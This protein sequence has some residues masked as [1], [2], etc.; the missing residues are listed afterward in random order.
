MFIF[1]TLAVTLIQLFSL[2]IFVLPNFAP[3]WTVPVVFT[4][5]LGM[6][7]G[8][9]YGA[10]K[11]PTIGVVIMGFSLG[12]L[13]GFIIYWAFISTSV[14]TQIAKTITA[15]ATGLFMAFLCFFLADH[16]VIITSGIFGAYLF[17]RG[18]SMYTGGYVNEFTVI[19]ATNNGD[20]G[21]IKW[22]MILYW[23]LMVLMAIS[24]IMG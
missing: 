12:S 20:L 16:M 14:D 15:G 6:G 19:L 5:C 22:T 11:W 1:A 24:G 18:I 21:E 17:I 9:G 2:F 8:M 3:S 23:I 7:V 13:L 4:V 10:S